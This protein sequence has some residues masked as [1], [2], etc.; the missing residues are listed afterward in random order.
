MSIGWSYFFYTLNKNGFGRP[1]VVPCIEKF[2]AKLV[3]F[4]LTVSQDIFGGFHFSVQSLDLC[5]PCATLN[6]LFFSYDLQ[7]EVT[8]R[9]PQFFFNF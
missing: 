7:A 4:P 2:F 5:F 9:L 8:E 1:P 6:K 3:V